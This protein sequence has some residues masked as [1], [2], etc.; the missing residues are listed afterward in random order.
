MTKRVAAPVLRLRVAALLPST[1]LGA[2]GG[3]AVDVTWLAAPGTNE[4]TTGTNWSSSPAVPDGTATFGASNTTSLN[5][6]N[7][8]SI[9]T[10]QFETGAPAYSFE[11]GPSGVVDFNVV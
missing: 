4:W 3:Q 8:T 9:G 5:I 7:S 10:I 11:L 6:S 2:T 1:C